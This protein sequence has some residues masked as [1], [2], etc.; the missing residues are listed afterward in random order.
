MA[1]GEG[2]H[3]FIPVDGEIFHLFREVPQ[4]NDVRLHGED[5]FFAVEEHF[6]HRL[7]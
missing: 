6:R 1:A 7:T 5:L 4:A 2:D 3:I